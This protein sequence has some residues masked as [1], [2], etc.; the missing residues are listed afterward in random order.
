M[1]K[2]FPK[3]SIGD[4]VQCRFPERIS[5]PG[6]KAR[7]AIVTGVEVYDLEEGGEEIFVTVAYGTSKDVD[8]CFPG[9]LKIAASDPDAGLAVDTKFD[10]GNLVTL[11]FDEEWFETAPGTEQGNP[12]RGSLN[13]KSIAIKRKLS[14][15]VA[16]LKEKGTRPKPK[17][18]ATKPKGRKRRAS[19]G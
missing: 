3:P 19:K 6:P 18:T 12:K 7:P 11:P 5:E 13:L 1:G 9:E 16:E 4:I 17:E 8:K 14:S 2:F 10:L 15:A